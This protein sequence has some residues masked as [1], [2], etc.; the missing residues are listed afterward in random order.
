MSYS[1]FKNLLGVEGVLLFIQ[2]WLGMSTNLFITVPLDGPL[3]FLGYSGGEEV[4]AHIVSGILILTIAILLLV[5]SFK[6]KNRIVLGFSAAAFVFVILAIFNGFTFIL[7]G[8]DD[9]FSMGMAV[10]FLFAFAFGFSSL[11]FAG[12]AEATQEALSTRK[13]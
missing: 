1:F 4:L 10:S 2:F 11:Y 13:T 3:N 7:Y 8:Q 6:L 5:Y 12:K 9:G